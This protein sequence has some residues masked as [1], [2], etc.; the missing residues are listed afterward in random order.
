MSLE[1]VIALLACLVAATSDVRT[2]RIPNAIP[3]AM[4]LVGLGCAAVH[5]APAVG[6][7]LALMIGTMLLGTFAFAAGW[8]GG[9]DVKL[10]AA[11]TGSLGL[12]DALPFLIYTAVCGGVIA[13][14][15]A[16]VS[17]RVPSVL[18]SVTGALRP[19]AFEGTVA[20]APERPI[21]MPY[22][23]AIAAGVIVVALSH[24]IAP[25]L[26]LPL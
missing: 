11:V 12:S 9:G 23:L 16:V 4:A 14:G 5:G 15:F 8:L 25:F 7:A 1:L 21:M 3:I 10:L 22:A 18:R 19:F 2:R 17:R 20:I 24:S 6:I 26:R 13:A